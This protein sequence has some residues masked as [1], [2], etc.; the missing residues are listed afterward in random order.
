VDATVDL[1]LPDEANTAA[2]RVARTDDPATLR[3]EANRRAPQARAALP[4]DRGVRESICAALIDSGTLAL[5]AVDDKGMR[6]AS[7]GFQRLL[8]LPALE[9]ETATSWC[10]RLHKA[11]RDRV[12]SLLL[13]AMANGEIA[14]TECL[15]TQPGG[16]AVRVHLA[17]YPAGP[18]SPGAYTLLLHADVASREVAPAPKLPAAVRRAFA[19]GRCEVLDRA[20][21]LLVD[22]WL[23]SEA[24]AVLA[25]GLRAPEAGWSEE[26]RHAA[27]DALLERLSP[28]LRDGDLLGRNGAQGLLIAIPNLSGACSAGIVAGRLIDTVA[29]SGADAAAQPGISINIGIAL[30]P[31][32]DQ[33]L[34]GLLAH[35]GAALELAR[36]G[37]PD[38][39]SLAETSLNLTLEPRRLPWDGAQEVGHDV[40][41]THHRDL[42]AQV[43]EV[44]RE[45]GP[46]ADPALLQAGLERIRQ[47]LLAEFA[48]EEAALE[49]GPA[50][51][52]DAHRREHQRV[53][54]NIDFLG[55]AES[56]QG[57]ALAIRFLNGWLERHIREFDIPLV[58]AS[59][60]PVW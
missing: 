58:E 32:D 19:R 22:A 35:A 6:F 33:E 15:V 20:G 1:Y 9:G 43:R 45:L 10:R 3:P 36:Q 55:R 59:Y 60:R 8:G 40:I 50:P 53:L 39:Y 34:S 24:L 51:A 52:G 14:A 56:H 7:P 28:C 49:A 11:D 48:A 29:R 46:H 26:E 42:L 23:K 27:E 38:A 41:D 37:G 5:A 44:A 57:I 18:A 2:S 21:D 4:I 17:G 30:F 47:A 31:D 16:A 25:V 54:R 12:S 13:H